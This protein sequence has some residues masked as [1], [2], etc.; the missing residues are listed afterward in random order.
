MLF[1]DIIIT[2]CG[3]TSSSRRE[4]L[5]LSAEEDTHPRVVVGS[6]ML[7]GTSCMSYESDSYLATVMENK[8]VNDCGDEKNLEEALVAARQL[9]R[10]KKKKRLISSLSCSTFKD[11]YSLTS[12]VLGEGSYGKVLSCVNNFTDVEY[13]VKVIS[14]S[15]WY[16]SRQKVLKEVELFYLCQGQTEIIQLIEYFEEEDAFYLI[17]EKAYG[18]PLLEQIQAKPFSESETKSVIRNLAKALA[19][20]HGKGIAHR[21][22]KPENILCLNSNGPLPVKL[23]DFD[24]CSAVYNTVTTPRLSSPVGSPEYMAPEV[25]K[26]FIGRDYYYEDDDEEGAEELTYDKK[27]DLW[28]LG[29]LLYIMVFGAMPFSAGTCDNPNCEW[30]SGGECMNCQNKLFNAIR[31]GSLGFPGNHGSSTT[32]SLPSASAIDLINQL[33]VKDPSQRLDA[34]DVLKHPWLSEEESPKIDSP[35]SQNI[36]DFCSDINHDDHPIQFYDK[37]AYTSSKRTFSQNPFQR[38]THRRQMKRQT[39]MIF[40]EEFNF[41][42]QL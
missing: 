12:E 14:K 8:A 30:N 28:S 17:F 26:A 25:V 39:S 42:S 35:P 5:E 7:T 3:S 40:P 18:G 19:F 22:I 1:D 20:L 21:D 15:S 37:S 24:L 27:C 32:T 9:K 2:P 11:I 4:S 41:K 13:A 31:F 33:L 38:T 34:V 6:P 16:Y 36:N 29:V 23:C 10:K